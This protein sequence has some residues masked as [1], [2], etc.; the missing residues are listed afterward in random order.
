MPTYKIKKSNKN[1]KT[2]L[3]KNKYLD[4]KIKDQL[5]YS[6]RHEHQV[7]S[8]YN[9]KEKNQKKSFENKGENDQWINHH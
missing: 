6:W 7:L 4:A 9:C 2:L 3:N 5:D 8:H 1:W